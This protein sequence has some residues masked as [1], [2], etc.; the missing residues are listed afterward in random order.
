VLPRRTSTPAPSELKLVVADA[1]K[2][3]AL[4]KAL[5]EFKGELLAVVY[6]GSAADD[7]LQVRGY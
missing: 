2:L 4:L 6:W 5:P 7:V 1:A 3:P